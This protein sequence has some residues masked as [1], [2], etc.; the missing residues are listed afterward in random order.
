MRLHNN[1]ELIE[2][3]LGSKLIIEIRKGFKILWQS[4]LSCFGAGYW[5]GSKPW[6]GSDA[7]KG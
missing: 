6:S 1:K 4:V 3:R 2:K 5:Q 7:W